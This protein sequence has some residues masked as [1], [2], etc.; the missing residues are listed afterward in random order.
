MVSPIEVMNDENTKL[1]ITNLTTTPY[2]VYD[3]DTDSNGFIF[4][5]T[6]NW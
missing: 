6:Y 1:S 2:K 5:P 4:E 3:V